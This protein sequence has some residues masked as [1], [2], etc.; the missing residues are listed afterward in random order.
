MTKTFGKTEGNAFTHWIYILRCSDGSYY[1]G[2]TLNLEARL[3]AHN[4]GHGPRYT[5]SRRP[6]RLVF[7]EAHDNGESATKRERQL[8]RW[9]RAKKQALT[10]GDLERLRSLSRSR[11]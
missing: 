1:V 10:E 3:S 4:A 11:T 8:K 6:V 5:R 2:R 9:S 7:Q